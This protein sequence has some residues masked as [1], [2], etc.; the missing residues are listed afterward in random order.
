MS[1]ERFECLFQ[2]ALKQYLPLMKSK[3]RQWSTDKLHPDDLFSEACIVL[4]RIARHHH[5]LGIESN[6]FKN[7]LM[8][9]IKNRILDLKR[10][11]FT[12][13]RN[14]FLEK[15]YNPNFDDL[16]MSEAITSDSYCADP[17][18]IFATIQLIQ[19]LAAILDEIDRKMLGTL[20]DPSDE[21]LRRARENDIRVAQTAH[22]RSR[23][24]RT[25]IPVYLLGQEIG[26]TYK[27]SLRSLDRIRSSLRSIMKDYPHT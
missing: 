11:Y 24:S 5:H 17:Q 15:N 1:K 9:S 23:G 4:M 21:L 18:E 8:K 6:Q 10:A 27:Q 26:L 22:R 19:K 14:Q 13:A 3:C 16:V 2:E 12:Q 7:L 20:L 25:E